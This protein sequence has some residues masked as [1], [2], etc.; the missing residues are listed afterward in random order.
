MVS[1]QLV[2]SNTYMS[3]PNRPLF[4]NPTLHLDRFMVLLVVAIVI[5]LSLS[6]VDLDVQRDPTGGRIVGAIVG[7]LVGGTLLLALRASGLARRE[8]IIADI[9]VAVITLGL[10][11]LAGLGLMSPDAPYG[12]VRGV[13]FLVVVA[14]AV[15][16]P[17]V[18]VRRLI[19][20]R[21]VKAATV[22]GAIGAY[23]F[24]PI[25]F[26]YTFLAV[27]QIQQEPFFSSAEPTTSFMYF[28]MATITTLGYGDL[29]AV[30][31]I[32]QYL[33]ASEAIIGQVY[34]VTCVALIVGLFSQSWAI[35]SDS[36]SN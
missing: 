7:L 21:Q 32:G 29:A 26:F 23:L 27:E 25:A 6:L 10:V 15:M 9:V 22:I 20:H 13:A 36:G 33:A 1:S 16:T 11:V 3:T 17:V 34:L 30:S 4:D 12:W 28:S 5:T 35:R 24:I 18:I 14:L 2:W 31:T 19:Q 8:Q